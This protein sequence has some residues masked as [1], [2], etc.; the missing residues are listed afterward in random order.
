MKESRFT[1]LT[2]CLMSWATAALADDWPQYR[3]PAGDGKSTESLG[4]L[5]PEEAACLVLDR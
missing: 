4:E 3:G 2:L 1:A 5:Q